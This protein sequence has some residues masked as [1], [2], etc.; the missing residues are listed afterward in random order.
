MELWIPITIGAAF[1]QNLRTAMQ[2]HLHGT[3]S[4]SGA[5]FIRFG[6]GLPFVMLYAVAVTLG[7][8]LGVPR[9]NQ[10]FILFAACGGIS[11]ILATACLL[12]SFG[13]RN[14]AV[15]TAYSK[16]ETVQT[17][18]FGIILLGDRLSKGA[19]MAIAVSLVGVLAL[20]TAKSGLRLSSLGRSLVSKAA[21]IGLASGALFGLSAVSYRAAS[22]ALGGPDFYVQAAYTLVW[23]VAI[24][25]A[26][27]VVYLAVREPGQLAATWQVRRV[28]ILVGI[29][30]AL[31]SAGWFT[32]MTLQSAAYVRALGQ[33][34]L[35][36]TFIVSA[37]VFRER[38]TPVEFVGIL[39][40]VAG[41]LVLLLGG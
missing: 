12:L 8:D 26:I 7:F 22:L 10:A 9:P 3:L 38:T 40:I 28:A 1:F 2:K 18:V 30:S 41:I 23:A 27:M 24:Q 5:T 4:T 31:G 14:F 11:Q 21:L 37:L 13:Q 34:E 29:T 35:V 15:G 16:T 6:Y 39:L 33:I 36:F 20:S 17:A 32:A 25:T 19:A